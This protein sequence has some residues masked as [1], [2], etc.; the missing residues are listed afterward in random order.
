MGIFSYFRI[1]NAESVALLNKSKSWRVLP[2]TKNTAKYGLKPGRGIS[3]K[4]GKRK[5]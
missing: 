2:K 3:F 1:T 4:P 5:N